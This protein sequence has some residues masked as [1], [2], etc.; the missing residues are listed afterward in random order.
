MDEVDQRDVELGLANFT[1]LEG[2]QFY[3]NT[4]L[5]GKYGLINANNIIP[6]MRF[7]RGFRGIWGLFLRQE[8]LMRLTPQN[9][10]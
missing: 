5:R 6:Y 9:S 3:F 4:Y 2:G 7:H 1:T 10:G 8:L